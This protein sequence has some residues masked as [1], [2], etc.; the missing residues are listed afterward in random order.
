[1]IGME[2]G[3]VMI[4]IV[5]DVFIPDEYNNG[6]KVDIL[7]VSKIGFKILVDGNLLEVIQKQD[8]NNCYIHREDR[9]M[10]IKNNDGY[11]LKRL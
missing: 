3:Y 10:V 2:T 11:D 1:M 9:V 4:G 8:S 5:K 7:K 6:V